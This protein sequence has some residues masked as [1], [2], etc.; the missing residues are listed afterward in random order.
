MC[1]ANYQPAGVSLEFLELF[2]NA[3][4]LL[5]RKKRRAILEMMRGKANRS[6]LF[7]AKIFA[8]LSNIDPNSDHS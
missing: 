1:L 6:R 8:E 2:S 7:F 5:R 3:H 4:L